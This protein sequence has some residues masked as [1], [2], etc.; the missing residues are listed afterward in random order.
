MFLQ[1]NPLVQVLP[2]GRARFCTSDLGENEARGG[3]SNEV[4]CAGRP[5]RPGLARPSWTD[6]GLMSGSADSNSSRRQQWGIGAYN[7]FCTVQ[8]LLS[9]ARFEDAWSTSRGFDPLK[10]CACSLPIGWLPALG[11]IANLP[12]DFWAFGGPNRGCAPCRAARLHGAGLSAAAVA[13]AGPP[14]VIT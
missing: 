1:K 14:H 2:T 5:E 11:H 12:A 8:N 13:R 7:Y 3:S 4:H 6:D 10:N 9:G